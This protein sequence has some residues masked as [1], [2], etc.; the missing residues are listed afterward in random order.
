[1][2]SKLDVFFEVSFHELPC[3]YTNIELWDYLGNSKLDISSHVRKSVIGGEHAQKHM[4]EYKHKGMTHTEHVDANDPS[5]QV[6]NKLE[7]LTSGSYGR[8]LKE[9]QYTFVLYYVDWCMFCQMVKPVWEKFSKHLPSLRPNVKIAQLNCV[10]EAALCQATK[11]AGYPSFI[12]FKGVNPLEEDYHDERTVAAFTKYVTRIA[13]TPAEQHPL[14]YQWHE[15]C[16][17]SGHLHINRVP[18]NFHVTAR[19]DA[20]NFDLKSTNTSHTIHHLSFGRELPN[21]LWV[22]VPADVRMNISPLDDIS[23]INHHGHMS[24]EH[25]IKVVSTR[26]EVGSLRSRKEILGYQVCQNYFFLCSWLLILPLN[27]NAF[28][29]LLFYLYN[30]YRCR[31]QTINISRIPTFPKL[32][33]RTIFHQRQ[34]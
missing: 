24:H 23:F 14:K 26:Y 6:A 29:F 7:E 13:D 1:M 30:F 12:M 28:F 27:A 25:Y 22:R 10:K 32:A 15:G 33:F 4:Q 20:H 34:L 3:R 17:L 9:N 31:L 8:F 21:D 11:I 18:G 19:S 5:H 2:E 16:L